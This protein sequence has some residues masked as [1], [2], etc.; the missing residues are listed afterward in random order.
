MKKVI[1]LLCIILTVVVSTRQFKGQ[2]NDISPLLLNNIEALAAPD[3]VLL[4]TYC[5]GVGSVDCPIDQSKVE[6]VAMGYRL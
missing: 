5:L 6:Y 3:E 1:F 4:P 2:K